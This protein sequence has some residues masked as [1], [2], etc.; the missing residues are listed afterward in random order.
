MKK[1]L[2]L[3]VILSLGLGITACSKEDKLEI[4][5]EDIIKKEEE[6]DNQFLT[7]EEMREA[8]ERTIKSIN[9]NIRYK[10]GKVL[11]IDG[12]KIEVQIVETPK[13]YDDRGYNEDLNID[14]SNLKETE[15]IETFDLIGVES[16]ILPEELQEL[17]YVRIGTYEPKETGD[18]L[19][20]NEGMVINIDKIN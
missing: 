19:G 11:N 1:T 5:K 6:I 14:I 18:A 2:L 13:S 17:K 9:E 8:N 10:F 7:E 16:N 15:K 4:Q 3:G 20:I 12:T